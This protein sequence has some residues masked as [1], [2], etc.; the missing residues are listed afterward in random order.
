MPTAIK[1][2]EKNTPPHSGKTTVLK[3]LAKATRTVIGST[4]L[5]L[6]KKEG[7]EELTPAD[8]R[9]RLSAIKTSLSHEIIAERRKG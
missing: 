4:I 3:K 7:A 8:L 1:K 9:K 5:P 6:L 2:H